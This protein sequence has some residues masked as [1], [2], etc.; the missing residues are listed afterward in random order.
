MKN[1][2]RLLEIIKKLRAPDGCPWDRA[3]THD[4]IRGHLLEEAAEFL[5]A[6]DAKNYENMKEELGDLLMHIM[7]HSE[8]AS[9]EGKFNFDDVAGELAE[10]LIRR[11]PHVFSG[12]KVESADDVIDIWT[13]VKAKEKKSRPK[14]PNFWENL[15]RELS[16]LRKARDVAKHIDKAAESRAASEFK[17]DTP[18]R[19]CGKALYEVVSKFRPLGVEPEGALRD[20]LKYL[21]EKTE[22]KSS[23]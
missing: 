12:E 14:S 11:H 17:A 18:E 13:A 4:S 21:R 3:Q 1:I 22:V 23:L 5:D 19:E 9:E 8:M 6:V 7:L 10:K 20:Y 16:A 2:D 15:P